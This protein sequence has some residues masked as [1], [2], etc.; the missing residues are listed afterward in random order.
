[1]KAIV[2]HGVGDIRLDDVPEPKIEQPEDVVIK[3]TASAICGTDLHFIRG[4]FP[5]MEKGTILGHEGVGV[6]EEV[7]KNVR[8][9]KVGDRVVVPSTIACGNCAYCRAGYYAQCDVANPHGLTAGTAFFGGP[10]GSGPFQGLQAEYARIP[11]AN[12]GLVGLPEEVSDDQAILLSDIFPTGWFGA[13]M[14]HIKPGHTVAIWGCGPVGQFAIASAKFMNAGR[15]FAIDRVPS[16]LEKARSQG[17]EVINFDEEDPVEMLR[18]L[19]RGIGV[20]CAIDCVGV[21]AECAH[22]GPA[23]KKAK[24]LKNEFDREL[25]H[26]APEQKP[27]EDN[28]HPGDAPTQALRW[29]I[30]SCAKAATLSIVGVY[31]PNLMVF[32]IGQFTNR[33]LR[34]N[35]GNCNHRKYIPQLVEMVR[36]GAI[37]PARLISQHQ[38]LDAAIDAYES[39]DRREGGWLK[40]E[41]L[42]SSQTAMH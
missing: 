30:E 7:G 42:P 4:T 6:I 5:G 9:F 8:N 29:M 39:F 1:M 21:D 41:L 35:A 16:R 22:K 17:A 25:K 37:D 27:H 26:V 23:A 36:M 3:L 24:A 11:F 14:A 19:T 33:N 38:P 20:D 40:V 28:W 10:K 32:P 2:Y 13:E 15:I 31:P 12:T 34:L 18:T